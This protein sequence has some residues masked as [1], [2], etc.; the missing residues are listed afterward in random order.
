MAIREIPQRELRN[1][2]S[3]VLREVENGNS[4][5]ITVRGK[6]VADLVPVSRKKRWLSREEV[7][8]IRAEAPLDPAFL[9]DVS[10]ALGGTTDEIADGIG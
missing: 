6:P 7:E 1:N 4:L 3:A 8:R 5:R 10:E 9:G 2:V